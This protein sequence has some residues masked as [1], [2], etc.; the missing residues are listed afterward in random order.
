[1]ECVHDKA[2]EKAHAAFMHY[3]PIFECVLCIYVCGHVNTYRNSF[4]MKC[5]K[6]MNLHMIYFLM[7]YVHICFNPYNKFVSLL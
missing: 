6:G 7:S 2:I 5:W 3:S 4:I 1:M